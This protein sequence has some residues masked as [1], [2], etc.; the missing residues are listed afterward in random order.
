M[1]LFEQF[2]EE[3]YTNETEKNKFLDFLKSILGT[4]IINDLKTTFVDD[5]YSLLNCSF[6]L[7]LYKGILN[8]EQINDIKPKCIDLV[9]KNDPTEQKLI[10]WSIIKLFYSMEKFKNLLI[11][12]LVIE[13]NDNDNYTKEPSLYF[14]GDPNNIND[15]F[16]ILKL[17]DK[18][19][20]LIMQR[21][22]R[23]YLLEKY[24]K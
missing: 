11:S 3:Y 13:Y 20:P 1:I 5:K 15:C 8:P 4:T 16:T 6:E 7:I 23:M 19:Y 2:V 10:I 18:F 14:L 17:N 22:M 21:E 12:F 24:I 9:Y